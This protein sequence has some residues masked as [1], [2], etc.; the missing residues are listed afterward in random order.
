MKID[1]EWLE[2]VQSIRNRL[3]NTPLEEI[4]L[5]H[6]GSRVNFD[7]ESL[8]WWSFTGLNNIDFLLAINEQGKLEFCTNE[9]SGP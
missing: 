5:Y 9:K 3:N 8:D 7:P 6:E 2:H 4:H 1:L